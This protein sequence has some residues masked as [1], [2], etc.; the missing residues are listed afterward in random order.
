MRKLILLEQRRRV[1]SAASFSSYRRPWKIPMCIPGYQTN[2]DL[3][4]LFFLNQHCIGGQ[5]DCFNHQPLP[6][7]LKKNEVHLCATLVEHFILKMQ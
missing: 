2:S 5:T 4:K 6:K 1:E 3:G 7:N